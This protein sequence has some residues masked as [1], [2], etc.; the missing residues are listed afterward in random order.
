MKINKLISYL[1]PHRKTNKKLDVRI[2]SMNLDVRAPI[3]GPVDSDL[4][5]V[6]HGK[7]EVIRQL[8]ELLWKNNQ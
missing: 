5:V 3:Y 4:T 1:N 6:F 7:S 8:A 2:I